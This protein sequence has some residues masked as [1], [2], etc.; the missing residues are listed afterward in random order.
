MESARDYDALRQWLTERCEICA[1]KWFSTTKVRVQA[2]VENFEKFIN[3]D[4]AHL[5]ETVLTKCI[6]SSDDACLF[7]DFHLTKY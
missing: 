1:M 5:L 3:F 2:V 6:L 4:T 7:K